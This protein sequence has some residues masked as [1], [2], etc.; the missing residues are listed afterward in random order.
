MAQNLPFRD[1]T[2]GN[3]YT[4]DTSVQG[5]ARYSALEQLSI[6][7]GHGINDDRSNAIAKNEAFHS[8]TGHIYDSGKP[9]NFSSSGKVTTENSG[10]GL[11][12]I[13]GSS[14]SGSSGGSSGSSGS[15]GGLF[16]IF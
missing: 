11:F 16:G 10:G 12:G 6:E 9:E 5:Y 1:T 8:G 2:L 13:F 14:S 7:Q 4:P 15:S 3:S